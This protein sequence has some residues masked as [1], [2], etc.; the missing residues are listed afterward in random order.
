ML[1]LIAKDDLLEVAAA[2]GSPEESLSVFSLYCST[3]CFVC[4]LKLISRVSQMGRPRP[5]P[6]CVTGPLPFR[7]TLYTSGSRPHFR[8]W[9]LRWNICICWRRDR[10]SLRA[11]RRGQ[12]CPL[13]RPLGLDPLLPGS[14]LRPLR[15][16]VNRPS[17]C[18]GQLTRRELLWVEW[19]AHIRNSEKPKPQVHCEVLGS[20]NNAVEL[21]QWKM[22][23]GPKTIIA[24]IVLPV[25]Q[26]LKCNIQEGH[27]ITSNR[28]SIMCK[29]CSL[30]RLA[31]ISIISGYSEG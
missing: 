13:T 19:N 18:G 12:K 17:D 15:L 1:F 4:R 5:R 21:V 25:S 23:R 10:R 11:R 20:H 31:I 6:V 28:A 26:S 9:S 14:L 27:F 2:S 22:G 3:V 7:K 24:A 29:I 8:R 30:N 16:A